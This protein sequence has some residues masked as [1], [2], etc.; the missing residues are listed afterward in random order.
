V[1]DA[2]LDDL[3]SAVEPEHAVRLVL[4]VARLGEADLARWWSSQGLNPAVAFALAGFRRTGR[5][6]GAELM[7]LSAVRRH[8]QVLPRDNAVHLFSAHLP[9]LH[10]AQAHL[11]EMKTSGHPSLLEEF[12]EWSTAGAA[13]AV[14]RR[15]RQDIGPARRSGDTVTSSKLSDPALLAWLVDGYLDT[16]DGELSV[17][18]V[19]LA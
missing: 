12:S 3:T 9:Y 5:V 8:R 14:I 2:V 7:L 18:Y 19:D 1:S 15:W 10:W 17:P 16:R 6:V 13:T 4:G 11:A